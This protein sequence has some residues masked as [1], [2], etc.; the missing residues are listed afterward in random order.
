MD[1]LSESSGS[2]SL[3]VPDAEFDTYA[4]AREKMFARLDVYQSLNAEDDT[5]RFLSSVF[6]FLPIQGQV[7]LADDADNCD[8]DD[9][10]RQLAKHLD[11]ALLRLMMVTGEN[12]PA[13]TPSPRLGVEDSIKNLLSQDFDS[14]TRRQGELRQIC[15]QRDNHQCVVTKF[16]DFDYAS[17]P[18]DEITTD[19]EAAHIIPFGLGNFH[20][21][22]RLRHAQIWHCLY[23]YFPTIRDIFHHSNEDVNRVDNVM[24]L[25][26]SLHRDFGRFSFILEE[27]DVFELYHVKVFSQFRNS[28]LRP[29]MPE[30]TVVASHDPRYPAPNTNLLAVHAA[31]GN[32]LHATGYGELIA[33]TIK[34][35][36]GSGGYALA[37]D[38]STNVEELLSV[39][40]LPIMAMNPINLS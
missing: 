5:V 28:F 3:S 24:M 9:R 16:W 26:A 12:T 7:H 32:I 38:G 4:A 34:H 35:L 37:K 2:L 15:L 22:E 31:I 6:R 19:L 23:R 30:F 18:P 11:T 14:A 33:K 21:D 17:R 39:T 40:S 13:I 29:H 1:S 20:E 36:G 25:A 27:T 10:L 8:N